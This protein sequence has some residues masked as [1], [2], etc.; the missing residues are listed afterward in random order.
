MGAALSGNRNKRI[1]ITFNMVVKGPES[2]TAIFVNGSV[3][4]QQWKCKF[5]GATLD[6]KING[7]SAGGIGNG[8]FLE[9]KPGVIRHKHS[10]PEFATAMDSAGVFLFKVLLQSI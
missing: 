4:D 3:T 10:D 9:L 1:A 5:K 2:C 7:D 6:V 8:T